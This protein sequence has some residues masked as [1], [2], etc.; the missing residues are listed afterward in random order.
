MA[1]PTYRVTLVKPPDLA[2][3][4]PPVDIVATSAHH[5][6][7]MYVKRWAPRHLFERNTSATVDVSVVGVDVKARLLVE[8]DFVA[9]LLKG[10]RVGK[11]A[12]RREDNA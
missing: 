6:A 11:R 2:K 12:L 1:K 4:A 9:V 8:F 7:E 3:T 5:A 10:P